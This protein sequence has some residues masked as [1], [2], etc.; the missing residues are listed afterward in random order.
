MVSGSRREKVEE[1]NS[2]G[3]TMNS[4]DIVDDATQACDAAIC[5]C[6]YCRIQKEEL[7]DTVDEAT[8]NSVE[9]N[10]MHLTRPAYMELPLRV[11]VGCIKGELAN[12]KGPRQLHFFECEKVAGTKLPIV[13]PLAINA[14]Q[15]VGEPDMPF[16]VETSV[17]YYQSLSDSYIDRLGREE[18][19]TFEF[20]PDATAAGP[21][22]P[23]ALW[24]GAFWYVRAPQMPWQ[25][26][27]YDERYRV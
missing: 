5:G 14:G 7:A 22:D 10:M 25:T 9:W 21:Q 1:V 6:V 2:D 20:D 11:F 17:E 16:N 15:F 26:I 19:R 12:W 8:P 13:K 23:F 27:Q 4:P 3:S 18:T 24:K